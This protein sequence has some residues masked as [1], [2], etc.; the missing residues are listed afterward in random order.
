MSYRH[1]AQHSIAGNT[2]VLINGAGGLGL[3][4]IEMLKAMYGSDVIVCAV[5]ISQAKLDDAKERGA[6]VTI[7]L[8]RDGESKV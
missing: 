4:A 8:P 1:D 3:W 6:D 5:D 2:H 7:C